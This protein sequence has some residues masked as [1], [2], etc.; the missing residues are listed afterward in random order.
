M[1]GSKNQTDDKGVDQ[2]SASTGDEIKRTLKKR[3]NFVRTA[4]DV[5]L[6]QDSQLEGK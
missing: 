5:L 6:E 2:L 3:S 4:S 1:K